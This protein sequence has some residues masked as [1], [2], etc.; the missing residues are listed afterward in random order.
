MLANSLKLD[1]TMTRSIKTK[2]EPATR[3]KHIWRGKWFSSVWKLSKAAS[4]DTG[5]EA[6]LIEARIHRGWTAERASGTP[7]LDKSAGK[8]TCF[9]TT[10][11][12]LRAAIVSQIEK[13]ADKFEL[14]E[15]SVYARVAT[16]G[17]PLER[18]LSTPSSYDDE[19]LIYLLR[20]RESGKAYIGRTKVDGLAA[21]LLAHESN[22]K[23]RGNAPGTLNHV[24]LTEGIEAFDYYVLDPHA[25]DGFAAQKKYIELYD[26]FN[27][28]FNQTKGG[29]PGK[30]PGRVPYRGQ[31]YAGIY[32][33]VEAWGAP[34]AVRVAKKVGVAMRKFAKT[35]KNQDLVIDRALAT[36]GTRQTIPAAFAARAQFGSIGPVLDD[37]LG[38]QLKVMTEYADGPVREQ[39]FSLGMFRQFGTPEWHRNLAEFQTTGVLPQPWTESVLKTLKSIRDNAQVPRAAVK[40]QFEKE[41]FAGSMRH[42]TRLEKFAKMMRRRAKAAARQNL[43]IFPGAERW[44]QE[45]GFPC[46]PNMSETGFRA[47]Q[48]CQDLRLMTLRQLPL[49]TVLEVLARRRIAQPGADWTAQDAV[50]ATSSFTWHPK[51][52]RYVPELER[53][54]KG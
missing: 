27:N 18:A 24:I 19:G 29:A 7:R 10:Y 36:V 14:S 12:S 20:H 32:G 54:R 49:R 43:Y 22:A 28:G 37:T 8:V 38:R 11:R 1:E 9:G 44:L 2:Q 35:E 4:L 16:L 47:H 3:K 21:R 52:Q 15:G 46:E 53:N 26:T 45:A 33:L 31:E 41:W 6:V 13:N 51:L 50:M 42:M 40:R 30:R 23:L 25:E 39:L 48:I 17:W 34:Q 5:V